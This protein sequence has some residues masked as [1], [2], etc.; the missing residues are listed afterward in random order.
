MKRSL[1][2]L[3]AAAALACSAMFYAAAPAQAQQYGDATCANGQRQS[4]F[5]TVLSVTPAFFDMQTQG[6]DDGKVRVY[7]R[8]ARVNSNGLALR[9]GTFVGAY[10][11]FR[12]D[13]NFRSDELTLSTNANSYTGYRRYVT[14]LSGVVTEVQ[15][16]RVLVDTDSRHAHVWV[17]TN[18]SPLRVGERVSFRGSFDPADSA[19][20]ATSQTIY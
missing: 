18:S 13:G 14:T 2:T 20:V 3:A 5:G 1:F 7:A 17:V 12:P 6:T 15:R 11:C 19:F 8:G 10:G 16:G 9:R 4:L